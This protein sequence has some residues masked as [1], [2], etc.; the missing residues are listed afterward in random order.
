VFSN[1]AN[2]LELLRR[3]FWSSLLV[4]GPVWA[5][6]YWL[7]VRVESTIPAQS[8]FEDSSGALAS[9]AFVLTAAL[10]CVIQCADSV[11]KRRAAQSEE[12]SLD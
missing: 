4:G 3:C 5:F 12:P 10:V 9:M 6:V 2:A 1:E 7:T 11:K 8:R